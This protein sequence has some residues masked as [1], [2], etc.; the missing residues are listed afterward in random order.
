MAPILGKSLSDGGTSAH[1]AEM[2]I[3]KLKALNTSEVLLLFEQM[4]SF[5]IIRLNSCEF[6]LV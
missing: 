4:I 3:V 2:Y 6:F 1:V 5:Y